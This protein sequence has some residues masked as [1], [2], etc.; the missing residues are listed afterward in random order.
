MPRADQRLYAAFLRL[1]RRF[2]GELLPLWGV[3]G[4]EV[5]F[6]LLDWRGAVR[7]QLECPP[8]G[9]GFTGK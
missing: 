7:H 4:T 1:G 9:A 5:V 3:A 8:P 6:P 2:E